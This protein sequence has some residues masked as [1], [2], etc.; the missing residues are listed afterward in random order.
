MR[1]IRHFTAAATAVAFL[2][3]IAASPASA[4]EVK[5]F[6]ALKVCSGLI[7]PNTQTCSITESSLKILFGGTIHYTNIV[8]LPAGAPDHLTSPVTFKA[9]D[10][11]G[12]TATG[13]CTFFFATG[14]G[15]CE[16]WAGTHRLDGFHANIAVGTVAPKTY[17]LAGTYWFD[18]EDDD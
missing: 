17:S 7:P 4:G 15:H 9:I 11:R 10:A 3:V 1:F 5:S 12:S 16:F 13:R 14:T 18:R 2:T 8:F 6:T